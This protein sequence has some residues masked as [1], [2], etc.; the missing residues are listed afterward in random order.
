VEL[1]DGGGIVA[2]F[3]GVV[4]ERGF[5]VGTADVSG[6]G[7]ECDAEEGVEVVGGGGVLGEVVGGHGLGR[8]RSVR[9]RGVG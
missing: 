8:D 4:F 9:W 7:L 2:Y 3:V 5:A 1:L 6:G